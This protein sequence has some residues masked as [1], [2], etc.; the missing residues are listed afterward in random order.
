MCRW[1]ERIEQRLEALERA[2]LPREANNQPSIDHSHPINASAVAPTSVPTENE[3]LDAQSL[4]KESSNG[5]ALNLASNLGVFPAS[6]IDANATRV[7]STCKLD[8][9]SRDIISLEVAAGCLDYFLMHLN[10]YIHGILKSDITLPDIRRRSP[11]LT[12]AVCTVASFCSASEH[13]RA[14]HDAFIAEVSGKLFSSTYCYD[15]IRALCIAAVW[16]DE[17]APTLNGLGK[18]ISFEPPALTS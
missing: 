14:C 10:Q 4:V 2:H 12:A 17:I 3:N 6:S 1:K 15:D 5:H 13:Y 11:L 7:I 16:L 18:S 9:V 8:I